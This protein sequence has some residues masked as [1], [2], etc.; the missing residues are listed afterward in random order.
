MAYKQELWDEAT[1]SFTCG[2]S[3]PTFSDR[4]NVGKEFK[5]RYITG[6]FIEI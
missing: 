3:H 1:I 2:D 5:N 6:N 4:V